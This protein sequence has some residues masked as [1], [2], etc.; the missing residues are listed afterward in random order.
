MSSS[1]KQTAKHL[2]ERQAPRKFADEE[3]VKTVP[4]AALITSPWRKTGTNSS[5]SDLCS[6]WS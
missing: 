2:L 4:E 6:C 5:R 3:T 1:M